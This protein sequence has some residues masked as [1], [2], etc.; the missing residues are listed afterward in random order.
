MKGKQPLL[1]FTCSHLAAATSFL[2]C[3]AMFTVVHR[4]A[5]WAP[6]GQHDRT[7]RGICFTRIEKARN[8]L[9]CSFFPVRIPD[10]ASFGVRYDALHGS[11]TAASQRRWI[12][13]W[14]NRNNKKLA[15]SEQ[16]K[17]TLHVRHTPARCWKSVEAFNT[18]CH[19]DSIPPSERMSVIGLWK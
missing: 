5:L 14:K 2:F 4:R 6:I 3:S 15:Q 18:L 10:V 17:Q 12:R 8:V 13:Y 16:Q 7:H 11:L 19:I 9:N 1:C